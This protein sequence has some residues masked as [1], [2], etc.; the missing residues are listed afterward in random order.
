MEKTK[1]NFQKSLAKKDSSELVT[2]SWEHD[3]RDGFVAST[4]ELFAEFKKNISFFVRL[5]FVVD[6]LQ[7][8]NEL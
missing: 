6:R 2:I 3:G 5:S 8:L 7:C 4:A 1:E